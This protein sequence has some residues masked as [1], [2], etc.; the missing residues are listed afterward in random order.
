MRVSSLQYA[1]FAEST[2]SY[3]CCLFFFFC[4]PFF[5]AVSSNVNGI[6]GQVNY[7]HSSWKCFFFFIL[8]CLVNCLKKA[9]LTELDIQG[10]EKS[11]Q[12]WLDH[13]LEVMV[14]IHE[15]RYEY[16]KQSQVYVVVQTHCC[17]SIQRA[18]ESKLIFVLAC[19]LICRRAALAEELAVLRQVDEFALKGLSPPRQKNGFSRWG[20][21][22][23]TFELDVFRLFLRGKLIY[24]LSGQSGFNVTNC[25]NGKDCVS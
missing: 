19:F 2:L 20:V 12:R 15:V 1:K 24:L 8:S 16:E 14:H 6:N 11:L 4:F 21:W 5:L 10:N 9:G 22:Y 17:L 25:K 23:M 13:E 7:L 3:Y 18:K